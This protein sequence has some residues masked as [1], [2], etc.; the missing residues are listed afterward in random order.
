[1]KIMIVKL[2]KEWYTLCLILHTGLGT[3]ATWHQH[4]I[5][6]VCAETLLVTSGVKNC[7]DVKNLQY[8]TPCRMQDPADETAL[9]SHYQTQVTIITYETH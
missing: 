9:A 1:M 4:E 2:L 6:E 7:K 8:K 5:T 3:A